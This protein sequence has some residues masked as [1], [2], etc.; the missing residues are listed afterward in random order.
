MWAGGAPWTPGLLDCVTRDV[1]VALVGD[2][3]IENECPCPLCSS[4]RW[5]QT[6]G[7][8]AQRTIVLLLKRRI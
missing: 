5:M 2:T 3:V 1:S 4:D 8:E 6:R 7:P